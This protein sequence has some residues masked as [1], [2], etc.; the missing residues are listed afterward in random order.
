MQ[1]QVLALCNKSAEIDSG[2][3]KRSKK[4]SHYEKTIANYDNTNVT[5]QTIWNI[6]DAERFRKLVIILQQQIMF[7]C[8]CWNET[9]TGYCDRVGYSWERLRLLRSYNRKFNL[10]R[11]RPSSSS[12]VYLM[13][14]MFQSFSSLG[15][16]TSY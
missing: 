6:C 12:F 3:L 5:N 7:Q 2:T 14:V 8:S 11:L 13:L 16:F 9:K 1:N 10:L 15:R 4:K